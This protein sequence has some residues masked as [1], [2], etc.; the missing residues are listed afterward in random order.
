FSSR[1]RHTRSTRDW[2]SDVCSSDLDAAYGVFAQR[3]DAAGTPVGGELHVNTYTTS[4][5]FRPLAASD[6]QGN[7]V[8]VWGSLGQDGDAY[9]MFAQRYDASGNPRGGEFQVNTYTTG[10][11]GSSFYFLTQN[12][13]I[14]MAPNGNF[15]VVWGS[16][17]ANQDG[18][19]GTV[20]GESF[21]ASGAR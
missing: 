13:G 6:R 20:Q 9:G 11:Q 4:Y 3:Y 2:S 18:S 15:V 10:G 12:S 21:N 19:L 8:V 17:Y 14:S 1:R 5:Q 7:F 16:Y